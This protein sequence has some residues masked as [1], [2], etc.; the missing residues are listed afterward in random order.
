MEK[1]FNLTELEDWNK[2]EATEDFFNDAP[3]ILN[4]R[5]ESE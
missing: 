5:K 1:K 2:T 4:L 3:E